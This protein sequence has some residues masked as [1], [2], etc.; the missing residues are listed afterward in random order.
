ML[1]NNIRVFVDT[2]R[3]WKKYLGLP[4]KFHY[5]EK[6]L[7]QAAEFCDFQVGRHTEQGIESKH[8]EF[9][10]LLPETNYMD[11]FDDSVVRVLIKLRNKFMYSDPIVHPGNQ[12]RKGCNSN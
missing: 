4:L 1:E 9:N 6:H 10:S 8:R 7:L 11:S 2:W 3:K 5:V 12:K